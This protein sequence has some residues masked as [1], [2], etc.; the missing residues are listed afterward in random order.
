MGGPLPGLPDSAFCH[1]QFFTLWFLLRRGGLSSFGVETKTDIQCHGLQ[2]AS[3][4]GG[5]GSSD[6][7]SASGTGLMRKRKWSYYRSKL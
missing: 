3:L 1:V 2:F 7:F 4:S 6:F 5:G